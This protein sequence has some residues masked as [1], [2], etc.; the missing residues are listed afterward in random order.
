MIPSLTENQNSKTCQIKS[1]MIDFKIF[2]MLQILADLL[3]KCFTKWSFIYGVLKNIEKSD[4]P[5]HTSATI[6]SWNL[7]ILQVDVHKD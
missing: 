2:C 7:L 3:R 5:P 6:Q 1:N 4:L